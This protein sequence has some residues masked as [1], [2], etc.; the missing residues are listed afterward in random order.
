MRISLT[1]LTGQ[2]PRDVVINGDSDMTITSV[3]RSLFATLGN[4]S[5]ANGGGVAPIV[6][7]FRAP[8]ATNASHVGLWM[9]GRML[10]PSAPAA[11]VLRDGAIVTADQRIAA[12][13]VLAEP[14]G[15]VEIRVAGGPAA[16]TVHRLGIGTTTLGGAPDTDV[17]LTDPR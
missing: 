15:L 1:A 6:P 8:G 17:R 14:T 10:D 4:D 5:P 11:R 16:G 9:D 12:A 2:G 7:I 3:A 13:T